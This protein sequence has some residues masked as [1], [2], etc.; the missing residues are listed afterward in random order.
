MNW[1]SKT[2][3]MHFREI[4]SLTDKIKCLSE[5]LTRIGEE[6]IPEAIAAAKRGW[7]SESGRKLMER[8]LKIGMQ[9]RE[10]SEAL[11]HL[12]AEMKKQAEDMYRAEQ[13]NSQLAV[14][15]IY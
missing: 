5:D 7:N 9:V 6:T 15:R 11:R 14:T 3:E 13:M 2:I 4:L 1:P 8:E 10:E 12:A